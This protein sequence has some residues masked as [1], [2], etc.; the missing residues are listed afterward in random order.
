M[1]SIA[2]VTFRPVLTNL[3]LGY[4][5][6][7]FITDQIFPVVPR[8]S[9][10]GQFYGSGKEMFTREN[11][12]RGLK[13]RANAVEHDYQT[14]TYAATERSLLEE[15]PTKVLWE[16]Q[17]SGTA[18]VLN[19]EADAAKIVSQKLALGREL[20]FAT[21]LRDTTKYATGNSVTLSGGG[22][23]SDPT[24]DPVNAVTGYMD[25][26]R[27]KIGMIPNLMVIPRAVWLKL[28]YH[29]KIID[30]MAVTG[31]RRLTTDLFAELVGIDRILTPASMYNTQAPPDVA[32]TFTSGDIWGKDVQLLRVA[33]SP[34]L[35]QLSFGYLFRVRYPNNNMLAEFRS[36]DEE[37]RRLRV[38]EGNYMEDRKITVPE[39]GYLIKAAVA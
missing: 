12:I 39:A 4:Q 37:D 20:D 6:Q 27:S 10:T 21:Q 30:K 34:G 38:I 35:N 29:P 9:R 11:D 28:Q 1:P 7:E 19:I 32:E 3:S 33:D 36:W 14:F 24:S 26:V 15:I 25:V 22:Q 13:D 2:N 23:W 18:G 16:A 5:T 31:V 17:T 8:D